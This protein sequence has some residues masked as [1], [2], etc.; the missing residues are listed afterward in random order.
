M[1]EVRAFRP[2]AHSPIC[3]LRAFRPSAYS[4]RRF[5]LTRTLT[6]GPNL[7]WPLKQQELTA[8]LAAL[9]AFP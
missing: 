3:R 6:L 7:T 8:G 4:L 9:R 5:I 1:N 2:S